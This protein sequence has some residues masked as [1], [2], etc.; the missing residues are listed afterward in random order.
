MLSSSAVGKVE[1]YTDVISGRARRI[2]DELKGHGRSIVADSHEVGAGFL[3]LSETEEGHE[4]AVGAELDVEFGTLLAVYEGLESFDNLTAE[5]RAGNGSNGVAAVVG[6][7]P[8]VSG[9]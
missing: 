1:S 9:G 6:E 5:D 7:V 3:H 8:F 4:C 2:G